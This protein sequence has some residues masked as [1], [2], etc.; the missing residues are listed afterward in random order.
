[1]TAHQPDVHPEVATVVRLTAPLRHL[2]G[3]GGLAVSFGTRLPV[4]RTAGSSV[5]VATPDGRHRRIGAGAVVVAPRDDAARPLTRSAVLDTAYDFLGVPYLWG[6]RSGFA[7]DCSGFT[8]L[9][10]G[11][12]GVR[13]PRDADDQARAGDAV[14]AGDRHATDLAFFAPG[15]GGVTHV[16]M[17][18]GGGNLIQAP[19]TGQ[20]VSV[21]RVSSVPGLVGVRRFL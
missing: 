5:V 19:S 12:H 21:A 3:S 7:V 13:L 17:L 11:V 16:A 4:V 18:V 2:D 1:V 20:T 6:G 14:A 8:G 10:Y 9:V 15:G